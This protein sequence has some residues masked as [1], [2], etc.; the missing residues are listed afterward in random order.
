MDNCSDDVLYFLHACNL[1]HRIAQ[2]QKSM[3]TTFSSG[4]L[5]A[6]II[7][8]QYPKLIQLHNYAESTNSREKLSNWT[9]LNK[10]LSLFRCGLSD[11]QIKNIV[12]RTMSSADIAN[13]IRQLQVRL[14]SYE[15]IYL[16]KEM[17][18]S[19]TQG[20]V[21]GSQS[22]TA[23]KKPPSPK[24][25]APAAEKKG[26]IVSTKPIPTTVFSSTKSVTAGRNMTG[27]IMER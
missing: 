7:H 11:Q 20:S 21:T 25:T 14:P 22:R 17:E 10:K 8:S 19:A 16:A 15:P 4:V 5:V 23:S 26:F 9:L 24:K 2:F 18:R 13:I 27:V 12:N 3:P 6:E 1:G